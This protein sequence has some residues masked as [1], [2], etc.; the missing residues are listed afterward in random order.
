MHFKNTN[1]LQRDEIPSD[2][3]GLDNIGNTCY[4]NAILQSLFHTPLF[5]DF[6]LTKTY[7]EHLNFKPAD[8]AAATTAS[9]LHLLA[10]A[11]GELLV[12]T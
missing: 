7:T 5:R 1:S 4:I 3:T 9:E 2:F 11:Y 12:E 6:F 8:K 10:Q